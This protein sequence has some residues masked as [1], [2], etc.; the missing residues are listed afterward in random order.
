MIVKLQILISAFLLLS[1]SIFG[2]VNRYVVFFTDKNGSEFSLDRPLEF[3][4]QRSLD[5]RA[6][7]GADVTVEDLPVNET[8]VQGLTNSGVSVFYTSRWFNA[9]IVE[10]DESITNSITALS[11]VSNVEKVGN[12]S[13]LNGRKH[14]KKFGDEVSRIEGESDF[15]INYIGADEMQADGYDGEG[16]LIAVTDGGFINTH[17]IDAF[18][19]LYDQGKIKYTFDY[20]SN[21]TF[22]YD[23]TDHG[24]Q[25]LSTIGA[26]DVGYSGIAPE[27][28]FMLFVTEDVSTENHV[29]EYNW[30]LAA[31]FADSAG[32]DI[33]NASIGYSTF[34]EGAD[35]SY[36]DLDGQ[37]TV[38]TRA[39]NFAASKGML[40][41]TGAG[42][43]GLMAWHY[44]LA[45]GDSES[46]LTVGSVSSTGSVS[47][48]SGVGP[49]F[50]GRIKP[51][52]A[53]F[54]SSVSVIN[55]NGNTIRVSG[56]SYSAPQIAGFAAG[57][58][59]AYPE[60]T[61]KEIISLIK[62]SGSQASSP[63]NEVGHG[64]PN[65]TI[66]QYLKNNLE[67]PNYFKVYPNPIKED[68]IKLVSVNL[69]KDQN[70]EI[71]FVNSDGRLFKK[72]SKKLGV[73][74]NSMNL[75]LE[76]LPPGTY[77]MQVRSEEK[78]ESFRIIK[79]Q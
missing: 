7:N 47:S 25:V 28:E 77:I 37:T 73:T 32:V 35:Y 46:V 2:Q 51:D 5:R 36:D 4:S 27:A 64:V 39:A 60:L 10:M 69:I 67:L 43:E 16:V 56:T 1:G 75:S 76:F 45:P 72:I 13:K 24:T 26:I 41:V 66:L 14:K 50:D 18:S 52:V 78:V 48:F 40:V 68:Q 22:V 3:L 55:Q 12:Q 38:I 63:D 29:E 34:L 15:Q 33:I 79:V 6:K 42:N 11:Y 44:I 30:L 58:M 31:E 19:H 9:A 59:Q 17:T 20:T 65:Y 71:R 23:Y 57:L 8:Y 21:D 62:Q 70:L 53:T 54:G 61:V 74:D 49:T